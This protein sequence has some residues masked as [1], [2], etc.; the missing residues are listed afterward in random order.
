[1]AL[2]VFDI[3]IFNQGR[4]LE[5]MLYDT[6]EWDLMLIE[7]ERAF[8]PSKGR[9]RHLDNAPVKVTDGWREALVAL[10]D[11][12]LEAELGDVLDRKRLRA[13][14]VRRDELLAQGMRAGR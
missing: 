7:H 11:E 2:Y 6:R 5:R 13:L 1:M 3:L 4:T 12:V 14:A 8:S 9:P 10:S